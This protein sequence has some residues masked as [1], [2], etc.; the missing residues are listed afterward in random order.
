MK[1]ILFY[2]AAL[3]VAA[4][5]AYAFYEQFN[6]TGLYAKLLGWQLETFG[7]AGIKLTTLGAG[8]IYGLPGLVTM[9]L[10]R[11]AARRPPDPVAGQRNAAIV[12]LVAG[13]LLIIAGIGGYV[14]SMNHAA[15][16]SATVETAPAPRLVSV[17]LDAATAFPPAGGA[18]GVSVTGWLR[19]DAQY[20][21]EE[22]GYAGKKTVFC[23][24]VN[25]RWDDSEPVKIFLRADPTAPIA[26]SRA[27][28]SPK[29]MKLPKGFVA[30]DFE[31]PTPLQVTIEG[32][33][34]PG[35][36]PDYAA[37]FFKKQG[38]KIAGDYVVLE[39]KPFFDT[40]RRSE[41]EKFAETSYLLTYLA[42]PLALIFCLLSIISFVR[43]RKLLAQHQATTLDGNV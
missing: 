18:D 35:G 29:G 30:V 22:K 17:D 21:L 16:R 26:L 37:S 10:T 27:G 28:G 41:W 1:K 14:I 36:L 39:A 13:V 43:W 34:R 4:A 6:E 5:F 23:P 33:T 40:P 3:W 11:S 12:F 15:R 19:R 8:V 24:F 2:L 20:G 9:S 31:A 32:T 25:A 42:L 7:S 38:V